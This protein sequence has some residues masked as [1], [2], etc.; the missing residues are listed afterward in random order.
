LRVFGGEETRQADYF[1]EN[2][3]SHVEKRKRLSMDDDDEDLNRGQERRPRKR[4]S[5]PKAGAP[6]RRA[7]YP[8]HKGY[9]V[10]DSDGVDSGY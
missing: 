7:V 1:P 2:Y 10:I 6:V 9:A 3:T 4:T 5:A 8:R